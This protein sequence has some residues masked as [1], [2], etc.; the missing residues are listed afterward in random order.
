MLHRPLCA[1]LLACAAAVPAHAGDSPYIGQL[2]PFGGTFCPVNWLPADGRILPNSQ[3][4]ALYSVIGTT[5]GG[6]SASGTFN[7]PDLRARVPVGRGQGPGLSSIALGEAGGAAS[8]TLDASQMPPHTHA[9][10]STSAA[11]T[12]TPATGMA[13]AATQNAGAYAAAG[14]GS[15]TLTATTQTGGIMPINL[16]NPYLGVTWCI[17]TAGDLPP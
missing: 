1:A 14:G 3:Y 5:Y 11:T 12:A 2:M 6:D 15:I 4:T 17:A 13:L 16:L 8:V 9:T 10:A 7:L